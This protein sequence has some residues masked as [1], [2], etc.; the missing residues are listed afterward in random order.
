MVLEVLL[1]LPVKSIVRFRAVCRSWSAMFSS[2]EF[3]CL[4]RAMSKAALTATPRLLH[5]S[6]TPGF[7]STAVHSCSPSDPREDLLFTLDHARGNFVEVL[8]PAPCRGLTLLYDA[9]PPAYYICNAATRE[10]TRL[11]PFRDT[12]HRSSAGLGFDARTRKYK[13]VRLINGMIHEKEMVKCEV[14]TAGGGS[15]D[16]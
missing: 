5:V 9:V 13:V 15:G 16:C 11:P 12:N 2:E 8:T 10:V 4:H 1:R 3:F 6:P 14:Y 7:H